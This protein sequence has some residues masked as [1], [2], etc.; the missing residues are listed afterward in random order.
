[1]PWIDGGTTGL[2][3]RGLRVISEGWIRCLLSDLRLVRSS[4]A[5][6]DLRNG[7]EYADN[8]HLL[9]ILST[10]PSQNEVKPGLILFGKDQNSLGILDVCR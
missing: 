6:A 3:L 10:Q 9:Y 1:M 4:G 8:Y 7:L 2:V 5:A